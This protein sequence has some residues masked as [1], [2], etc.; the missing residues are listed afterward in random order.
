M[1]NRPRENIESCLRRIP[2]ADGDLA[3]AEAGQFPHPGA[4]WVL[5]GVDVDVDQVWFVLRDGVADGV[6]GGA[7]AGDA[8]AVDGWWARHRGKV[9]VVWLAGR[10]MLEVGGKLAAIQIAALQAA[11]RRVGV[12]VP[13]HPNDRQIV[14]D[15]GAKHVGVHEEGAIATY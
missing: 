10:R 15:C 3:D 12:I 14:F 5:I 7:G 8:D 11:D 4:A 6:S 2:P 9:R 13:D 1:T